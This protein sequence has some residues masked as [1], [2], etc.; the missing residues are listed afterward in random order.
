MHFLHL[1]K[2]FQ[3]DNYHF[4]LH[5][6]IFHL[7]YHGHSPAILHEI[8]RYHHLAYPIIILGPNEPQSLGHIDR[9]D[10][11]LLPQHHIMPQMNT[12]NLCPEHKYPLYMCHYLV[13]PSIMQSLLRQ[14]DDIPMLLLVQKTHNVHHIVKNLEKGLHIHMY[15]CLTYQ[16]ICQYLGLLQ[17]LVH[18][19]LLYMYHCQHHL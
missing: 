8:H 11:Y 17:K 16:P 5:Q 6:L 2:G 15:H 19:H 7:L 10:I 3:L 4:L 9:L 14:S 13:N 12:N 1:K 18:A